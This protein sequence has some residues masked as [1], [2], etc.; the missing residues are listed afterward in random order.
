MLRRLAFRFFSFLIFP[1]I[2]GAAEPAPLRQYVDFKDS[3]GNFD[4]FK[5]DEIPD[6]ASQSQD[7]IDFS[8]DSRLRPRRGRVEFTHLD[9]G[10]FGTSA[11]SQRYFWAFTSTNGVNYG[12]IGL[13]SLQHISIP[14]SFGLTGLTFVDFSRPFMQMDFTNANGVGYVVS[15]DSRVVKVTEGAPNTP[16]RATSLPGS[17]AGSIIKPHLDRMLISGCTIP[18]TQMTVYFSSSSDFDKYPAD[19]FFDVDAVASNEKITCIGDS[20]FG[21]APLFTNKTTRLIT[22]T[23]YPSTE[24]AIDLPGNIS[25]KLISPSIG[26]V[27]QRTVKTAK[28][29]TMFFSGGQNGTIPGIYEFNGVSVKERTKQYRRFFRDTVVVSTYPPPTAFV[30]K[31]TYCL[32]VATKDA[33]G[34][35]SPFASTLVCLDENDKLLFQSDSNIGAFDLFGDRGYFFTARQTVTPNPASSNG[36]WHLIFSYD[37]AGTTQDSVLG[38]DGTTPTFY[39]IPWNYKTKDFNMGSNNV[40]RLK[41]PERLYVKHS[42]SPSTG[43]FTVT[44]IYDFGKS[45]TS[46]TINA[47]TRTPPYL[48]GS[49]TTVMN[50]SIDRIEK[51]TFPGSPMFNFINFEISGSSDVAI[52]YLDF[53]ANP[54][55]YR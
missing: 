50:T 28:G 23:E 53:Y 48:T 6:T 16:L 19:N 20:I 27:S 43:I 35:S 13:T 42:V 22:G 12:I 8:I 51:L 34:L 39:P 15:E 33:S 37:T 45:S 3:V 52:N 40:N 36:K 41:T 49:I 26:C 4:Y 11:Q 30:Y 10:S 17:P 46:W 32:Q 29:K 47:S 2:L 31:D 9:P 54:S 55:I 18:D 1:A 38:S 14:A 25:I 5:S 21:N 24:E 7:N 44:A